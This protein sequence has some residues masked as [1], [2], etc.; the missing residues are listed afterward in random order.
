MAGS[1]TRMPQKPYRTDNRRL[2]VMMKLALG[3]TLAVT[4]RKRNTCWPLSLSSHLGV[5]GSRRPSSSNGPTR[6]VNPSIMLGSLYISASARLTLLQEVELRK[7]PRVGEASKSALPPRN[8]PRT[9]PST[10]ATGEWPP[11]LW[12]RL[13]TRSTNLAQVSNRPPTALGVAFYLA[14]FNC[15][16]QNLQTRTVWVFPQSIN[17]GFRRRVFF[18]VLQMMLPLRNNVSE[19]LVLAAAATEET[20]SFEPFCIV[21]ESD[22]G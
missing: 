14:S 22:V 11:V 21:G 17:G 16:L 10:F 7:R 3:R 15:L 6:S 19:L 1:P 9:C 8:L 20:P 18:S 13:R 12:M 2:K 5:E 4:S